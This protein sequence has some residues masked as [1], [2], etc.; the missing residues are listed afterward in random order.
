MRGGPFF[1]AK[2]GGL[3]LHPKGDSEPEINLDGREW[4]VSVTGDGETFASGKA[5][6]GKIK[7]DFNASFEEY[8][9]LVAMRDGKSR[10]G[11]FTT[12]NG[13][14]LMVNGVISGEVTYN[15][16]TVSLEITGKVRLQ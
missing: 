12:A 3:P 10:A 15:N 8:K 14:V 9:K 11:T 16:G 2:F 6:P 7:S 1:D 5:V 13:D 4:D